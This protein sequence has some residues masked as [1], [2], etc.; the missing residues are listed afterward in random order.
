MHARFVA[1]GVVASGLPVVRVR[2]ECVQ[3]TRGRSW[4]GHEQRTP[5]RCSRDGIEFADRLSVLLKNDELREQMSADAERPT[6][7]R[8]GPGDRRRGGLRRFSPAV[9]QPLVLLRDD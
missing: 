5:F 1:L 8:N 6:L 3:G 4:C 9:W 2:R 7:G